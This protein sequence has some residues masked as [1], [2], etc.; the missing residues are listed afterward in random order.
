MVAFVAP[1]MIDAAK[2]V[3]LLGEYSARSFTWRYENSDRGEYTVSAAFERL[4]SDTERRHL[5]Q[6][7][8]ALGNQATSIKWGQRA[9]AY[10]T[11]TI[12]FT[13]KELP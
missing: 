6:G 1:I 5:I 11:I 10:D 8:L 3:S 9:D 2:L 13:T 4:I 7:I 12:H